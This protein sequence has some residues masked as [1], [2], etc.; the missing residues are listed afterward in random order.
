MN[1]AIIVAA[2]RSE[3]MGKQV[4]KAFVALGARPVVAHAI[5]SF[6][7]CQDIDTIVLVVRKNRLD[8]ARGMCQMFGFAKVHHILAGGTRRQ[9][10]VMAGLEALDGDATIVAV[11]DGARPCVTPEVISETIRVARRSGTAV[12]ATKVND[13][14][15]Y[16]ERGLTVTRTIDRSKLWAVQTPQTFKVSVLNDAF[17]AVTKK[18]AVVTDEASAVELAGGKVRLVESPATNIKITTV[19]DLSIAAALLDL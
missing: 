6:E 17:A 7:L 11:H 10:S 2:G 12:A 18:R 4:D 15:K 5:R 16:V 19:A 13:T 9:D 14:I 8:A 1:A 3:R